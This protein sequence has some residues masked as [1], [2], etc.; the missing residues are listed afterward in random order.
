MGAHLGAGRLLYG[1]GRDDAIPRGF[2]GQ[3]HP[4]TR[5]PAN[6][7]LLVGVLALLGAFVMNYDLGAQLLNF[8]ALVGF[9]GVNLSA[10]VHYYVRGRSRRWHH[11]WP[12]LFGFLVCFVLWTSLSGK[13]LLIGF[14]WLFL[15]VSYGAWKTRGYTR[16]L[17]MF[18]GDEEKL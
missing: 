1:M 8:G 2:F 6:N 18:T 5:I 12:P 13:A 14:L 16:P 7:I 10:L 17:R 11:L 9:M 3:L 4:K 15:G